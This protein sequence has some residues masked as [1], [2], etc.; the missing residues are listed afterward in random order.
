MRGSDP[1][2]FGHRGSTPLDSTHVGVTGTGIPPRLKPLGLP[3]RLRPPTPCG[4]DGNWHTSVPQKHWLWGFDSPCPHHA[5][6]SGDRSTLVALTARFDSGDWL[7]AR[8]AQR[9]RRRSERPHSVGS[10]PTVSTMSRAVLLSPQATFPVGTG[11]KPRAYREQALVVQRIR[12]SPSKAGDRGS[13]PRE[14]ALARS[15]SYSGL[16]T[17]PRRQ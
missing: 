10:N 5:S 3:V 11:C 14:G 6:R 12:R 15:A 16:S 2:G 8:V 1:R 9:Q 13:N 17:T 4:C 7:H